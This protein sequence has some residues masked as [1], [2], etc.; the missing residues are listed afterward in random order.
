MNVIMVRKLFVVIMIF[1]WYKNVF[2]FKSFVWLLFL[3][4]ASFCPL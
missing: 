3:S 4:V 1:S 2:N